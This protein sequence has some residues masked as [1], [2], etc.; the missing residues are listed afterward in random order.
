MDRMLFYAHS[1]LRYLVLL[2]GILALAYFA[3]GLATRKPF[4]KLGRI[5]GSAYSGLLQLQ[6]LLGVGVLVT[7]FYYPALIGHIV[8][9]VLA[10]GVAQATLSIN[11]R[12]P[13]PAFVLP[14]VGVVVSIVFI[15]GGIMA[16][17]RGVFTTTAM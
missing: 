14:L 15:I 10:A 13:Q 2:A 8:M 17:G 16:I 3:Y 5:L 9:M 1:G 4:D 7:R 12:K 11:R 6:V